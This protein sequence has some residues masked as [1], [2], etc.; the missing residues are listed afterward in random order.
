[1]IHRHFAILLASISLASL[2]AS[3]GESKVD[4][5]NKLA[6]PINNA[7]DAYKKYEKDIKAFANSKN[8]NLPAVKVAVGKF[9]KTAN[10]LLKDLRAY[11]K[12]IQIV[13][14]ED[15]K[16]KVFRDSY[17]KETELAANSFDKMVKATQVLANIQPK[18]KDIKKQLEKAS[19]DLDTALQK[20]AQAD[21]K[22][23]EVVD[24][25]NKYCKA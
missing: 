25:F 15:K 12:K 3:C 17:V 4:Q 23:D 8:D 13:N 14:L 9:R 20:S 11:N 19:K 18:S 1:L 5:C 7:Q 16:I 2:V 10:L 21:Q 6:L 22:R 24:S